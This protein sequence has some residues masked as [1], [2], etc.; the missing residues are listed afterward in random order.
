MPIAM[1]SKLSGRSRLRRTG[2][3]ALRAAALAALAAPLAA[4][5]VD[6]VVTGSITHEDY[7][8][9]H[10]IELRQEAY[11]LDL[12]ASSVGLDSRAGPQIAEFA[13]EYRRRGGGAIRALVPMGAD[14]Q[15]NERGIDDLRRL[16]VVNGIRGSLTV[17]GYPVADPRL[18]SPIRVSF[19]GLKAKVAT[20]CGEW[21]SDLASGSTLKGWENRSYWNHGCAYQNMIASQVADPRDLAD[22]RG[23]G[24]KDTDMRTRAIGNVRRGAD[25]GTV[26]TTKNSAIGTVGD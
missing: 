10:P 5:G 26:W 17:G 19:V 25:P 16:L 20:R 13:D 3:F 15:V 7:S 22:K 9:R 8:Q 11:T 14:A 21:P 24:P 23:E 4:C 1:L 2:R 12:F 18:A 6:R